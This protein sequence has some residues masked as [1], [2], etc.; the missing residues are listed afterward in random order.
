FGGQIFGIGT[1]A[2]GVS[3]DSASASE[4]VLKWAPIGILLIAYILIGKDVLLTAVKNITHGRIFDENFLM[5]IA[6][7]G[8]FIIGEYPE[9][10]A[11]MLFYSVGEYLQD[12]AV[13]HSRKSIRALLDIRPD[14]AEKLI[15]GHPVEVPAESVAID[16][17]IQIR[18]GGKIPLDG[19]VLEGSSAIDTSALTGESA[20]RDVTPG[21]TIL[22]GQVNG[23]GLLTV[24]VTKTFGESTASKIIDMVEHA[25]SKKAK[26][27]NFITVFARY[28][29]P[30][31][32]GV[33]VL[34]AFVPPMILGGG[35]SDWIHRGLIFI[36][37]SCPCALVISIPVGF[38]GGIGAASSK[39]LLVKGGNYLEAL[40]K[41]GTFVFDKTGTLT[42][43][44]FV[45]ER[46][47][48]AVTETGADAQAAAD[49]HINTQDDVLR[50]AAYAESASTH[51]I[52]VSILER[53][54]EGGGE[55][56]PTDIESITEEP[57]Y[58]IKAVV[59]GKTILAGNIKL[60]TKENVT[61]V[62]DPDAAADDAGSAVYIAV[63][64]SYIGR[65][66]LTDEPKSDSAAAIAGLRSR[67]DYRVIMLTGDNEQAAGKAAQKL[68]ILPED[69]RAGLLPGQKVEAVEQIMET[70]GDAEKSK[71]VFIGDG[72]NDAPVLAR[73]D[74]GIAMGGLG[75]DAAIEAADIVIMNDEPS[76]ILILLDIAK[77][78]KWI[79]RENV[80]FSLGV[81]G[82]VL[83][84]AAFGLANMWEAVFADVGVAIIATFNAL[85]AHTVK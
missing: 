15:N 8:A 34:L 58:G 81:K 77:K 12:R 16:D 66:L 61:A 76:R 22:S 65:I 83:L 59:S 82:L 24:R 50:Y 53:F 2:T 17:H 48:T 26:A 38:F 56:R 25:S 70:S 41:I 63:D 71:V 51:P 10:V 44:R 18:P 60:L 62:L 54:A 30:A 73:S 64:G 47:E 75:S 23:R 52:A 78:T 84:L 31:V 35:F 85:R 42:M 49:G 11:V 57:G 29:T 80:V 1:D 13:A 9:A 74:V 20:P 55:I 69:V 7:V 40:N 28:Y 19:I 67:G 36:V 32:V 43:G 68:G 27:E 79:V 37:V 72:I 5:A 45:V 46:I 14:T 33:A 3:G 21:D 6:S 39:G 4:T